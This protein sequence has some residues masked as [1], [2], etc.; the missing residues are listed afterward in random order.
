MDRFASDCVEAFGF[1]CASVPS[2]EGQDTESRPIRQRREN[3]VK[4]DAHVAF[5]TCTMGYKRKP[6]RIPCREQSMTDPG[7]NQSV[8]S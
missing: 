4:R 6:V 5:A 3:G 1:A 2:R 7:T 8:T